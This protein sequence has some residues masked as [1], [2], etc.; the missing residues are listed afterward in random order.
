MP[1]FVP[2]LSAGSYLYANSEVDVLVRLHEFGLLE[3]RHRNKAVCAIKDLA[4]D[5]PDSGFL[6][7]S[8]K[9]LISEHELSDIFQHVKEDLIPNL[10]AQI[11]TWHYSYSG[12]DSPSAHFEEL[13]SALKDYQKEFEKK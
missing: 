8:I 5:I 4:V 13:K 7:D 12:K 2:N 9:T 1:D 3:E 10:D 11:D 6:R